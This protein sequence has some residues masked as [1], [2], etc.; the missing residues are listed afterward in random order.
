LAA[1]QDRLGPDEDRMAAMIRVAF[2]FVPLLL[3]SG[4]TLAAQ[5]VL[6]GETLVPMGV[7]IAVLALAVRIAWNA[8]Q[9]YKAQTDAL[10]Q[11]RMAVQDLRNNLDA[12]ID[13][14]PCKQN[15]DQCPKNVPSDT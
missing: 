8:G 6:S 9:T 15:G 5:S 14:L 7:G 4:T 3:A 11:L 10:E 12:R 13:R 2:F 1:S